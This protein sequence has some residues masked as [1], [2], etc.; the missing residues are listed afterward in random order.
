VQV[1]SR[2]ID[3]VVAWGLMFLL[4]AEAQSAA[5]GNVAVA[6]STGYPRHGLRA[7]SGRRPPAQ[8]WG[9]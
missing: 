5:I 8:R 1:F 3:G 6:L 9:P 7:T 2:T 4:S